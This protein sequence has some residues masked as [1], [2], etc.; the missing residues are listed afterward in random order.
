MGNQARVNNFGRHTDMIIINSIKKYFNMDKALS[1]GVLLFL[2]LSIVF[3]YFG[4]CRNSPYLLF[5]LPASLIMQTIAFS[6]L[7]VQGVS[8]VCQIFKRKPSYVWFFSLA[9]FTLN[10]VCISHS[11]FFLVGLRC[12]VEHHAKIMGIPDSNE[13]NISIDKLNA[14]LQNEAMWKNFRIREDKNFSE[15]YW[16]G[17]LLGHW[18]IRI[19]HSEAP[20]RMKYDFDFLKMYKNASL[21]YGE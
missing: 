2:L 8:F 16:G 21:F 3:D 11:H 6:I 17:A 7:I 12:A 15:I 10:Y 18:G 13:K 4:G 1:I 20:Y 19:F 9:I 5:E 14:V